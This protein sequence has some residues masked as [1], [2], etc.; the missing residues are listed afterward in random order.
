MKKLRKLQGREKETQAQTEML[1]PERST[2]P[3][4][5]KRAV[6]ERQK[7]LGY[8]AWQSCHPWVL[9]RTTQRTQ[10]F[11]RT[12]PGDPGVHS[13][14]L[15]SHP[16]IHLFLVPEKNFIEWGD[17]HLPLSWVRLPTSRAQQESSLTKTQGSQH[18]YKK[19]TCTWGRRLC[20]HR[21]HFRGEFAHP[22]VT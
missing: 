19:D 13:S 18:V 22:P 17:S 14:I 11:S 7:Q 16:W 10:S 15:I 3:R 9:R 12:D 21:I 4:T 1:T 6:P 2:P 20:C 5:S 8:E